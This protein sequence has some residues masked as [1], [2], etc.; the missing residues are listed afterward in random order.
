MF[1]WSVI[2]DDFLT[3]EECSN[4]IHIIKSDG[5]YN[6]SQEHYTKRADIYDEVVEV[7]FQNVMKVANTIHYKWNIDEGVRNVAGFYYDKDKFKEEDTF[8]SDFDEVDTTHKLSGLVYLND[9]YDGGEL[10]IWNKKIEPKVGRLVIFPAFA[11]HKIK[12]FYKEDRY[13]MLFVVEGDE[14]V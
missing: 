14:F 8:H 11:A 7:R 9:D 1:K 4:Y 13:T 6:P 3:P 10:Q 2:K 5:H 12:Q